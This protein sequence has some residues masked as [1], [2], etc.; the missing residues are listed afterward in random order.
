VMFDAPGVLA[1]PADRDPPSSDLRRHRQVS[2]HAVPADRDQS[3]WNSEMNVFMFQSTRSLRTATLMSAIATSSDSKFQSTR[4][5]RTATIALASDSSWEKFQSTR[6]LRTATLGQEFQ[7][8]FIEV[9]IHAVPADRDSRC[10]IFMA[11][12]SVSIH[13]VPADRDLRTVN[14]RSS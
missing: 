1:V 10:G 2:I 9:S 12:P 11:R 6:S 7:P 5:L 4:S 8:P 14:A 3:G 13:A